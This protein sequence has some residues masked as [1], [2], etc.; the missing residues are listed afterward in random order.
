M[1]KQKLKTSFRARLEPYTA[2][3][4]ASAIGCPLPTAYDW[5]SG[6]RVPPAWLH[7]H[8]ISDLASQ[9][10][11]PRLTISDYPTHG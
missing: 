11:K 6:R 1:T 9:S 8:I 10:N 2:R 5:R 4:I 7:D 3:H